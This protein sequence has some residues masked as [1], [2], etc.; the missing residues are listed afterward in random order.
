VEWYV[1]RYG[2]STQYYHF[3]VILEEA[4]PNVVTYKY[5]EA[6]DKGAKCTIG[7]QGPNGKLSVLLAC[8]EIVLTISFRCPAVVLQRGQGAA[9]CSGGD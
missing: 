1:S 2:D 9:W 5:F 4:R 7:A 3:L 8:K 6:L